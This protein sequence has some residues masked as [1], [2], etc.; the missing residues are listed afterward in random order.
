MIM[1]CAEWKRRLSDARISFSLA[2]SQGSANWPGSLRRWLFAPWGGMFCNACFAFVFSSAIMSLLPGG[3]L[4]PDT[5]ASLERRGIA[6][7]A[8]MIGVVGFFI[9]FRRVRAVRRRVR[10]NRFM[11]CLECGYVLTGL[12]E[13]SRCPECGVAFQIEDVRRAWTK[14]LGP[15]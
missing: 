10:G 11:P 9:V 15:E 6:L 1:R 5:S 4:R 13:R 2:R 7:L 14:W 12:G 3:M 8:V